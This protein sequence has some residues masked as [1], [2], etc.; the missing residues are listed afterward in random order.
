MSYLLASED[1]E[2]A[3]VTEP[4]TDVSMVVTDLL[5]TVKDVPVPRVMKPL[6]VEA[7]VV[8]AL[9]ETAKSVAAVKTVIRTGESTPPSRGRGRT[10]KGHDHHG[11]QQRPDDDPTLRGSRSH[12]I[13]PVL[14]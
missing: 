8:E 1:D 9:V 12:H 11:R 3:P 14:T 6:A 5:E 10:G 4:L 7:V 13:S 2:R